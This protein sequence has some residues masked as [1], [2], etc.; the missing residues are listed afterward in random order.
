MGEGT[1]L[2]DGEEIL[3]SILSCLPV[4]THPFCVFP[5]LKPYPFFF[6]SLCVKGKERLLLRRRKEWVS[7]EKARQGN[8]MGLL[9]K[10][11]PLNWPQW[12]IHIPKC[13]TPITAFPSR[14]AVPTFELFECRD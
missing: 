1:N 3:E 4:L 6:L 7:R 5:S 12:S 11:M 2:L 9:Q 13:Y 10:K 14:E 8:G